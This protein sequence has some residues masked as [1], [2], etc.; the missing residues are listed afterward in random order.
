ME[1]LVGIGRH[2]TECFDHSRGTRF[3]AKHAARSNNNRRCVCAISLR[4][5]GIFLFQ[6]TV[7]GQTYRLPSL[8][9]LLLLTFFFCCAHFLDASSRYSCVIAHHPENALT[10]DLTQKTAKTIQGKIPTPASMA[11]WNKNVYIH[12]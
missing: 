2:T 4:E 3:I 9:F 10:S 8:F 12:T 7:G 1:E 5:T 6:N 11:V